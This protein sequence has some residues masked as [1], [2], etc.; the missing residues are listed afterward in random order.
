[1]GWW[2]PTP[3]IWNWTVDFEAAPETIIDFGPDNPTNSNQAVFMFHSDDQNS[4]FECMLI[5]SNG[6]STGWEPWPQCSPGGTVYEGFSEGLQQFFVR[7]INLNGDVDLTPA[8]WFWIVDFTRPDTAIISGPP[9][10]TTD[11]TATFHFESNE[12]NSTF[13][14]QLG[15]FGIGSEPWGPCTSPKVYTELDN[16]Y[17]EFYVRAIDAAGNIDSSEAVW[18]WTIVD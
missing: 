10:P 8:E 5:R 18:S 16:V 9:D 17:Y 7:A 6:N 1:M 4:T 12:A 13:E 11:T 15:K 2:D 14:C 3:A